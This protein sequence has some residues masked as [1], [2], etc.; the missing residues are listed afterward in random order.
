METTKKLLYFTFENSNQIGILKF[1]FMN[2]PKSTSQLD[3]SDSDPKWLHDLT[4]EKVERVYNLNKDVL[5]LE[6]PDGD[7]K[8]SVF[9]SRVGA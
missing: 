8:F 5:L 3:L 4:E 1:N 7:V 2:F 6:H 9:M